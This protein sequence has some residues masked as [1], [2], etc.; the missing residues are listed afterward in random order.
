MEHSSLDTVDAIPRCVNTAQALEQR[1]D[2]ARVQQSRS[3][4]FWLGR[5]TS[6]DRVAGGRLWAI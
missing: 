6:P 1:N 2:M 3:L 5:V 4:L